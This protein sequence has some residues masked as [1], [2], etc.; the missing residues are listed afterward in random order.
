M[1]VHFAAFPAKFENPAKNTGEL[2]PFT[3][4]KATTFSTLSI[5]ESTVGVN[6]GIIGLVFISFPAAV[7]NA[8]TRAV[9]RLLLSCS[10]KDAVS[11]PQLA[12]TILMPL[13]SS[14]AS[15][16]KISDNSEQAV[17]E[18]ALLSSPKMSLLANTAK[19]AS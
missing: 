6:A 16:L 15:V 8:E 13:Y 11:N 7:T 9:S 10:D 2:F 19:D 14:P 1:I 17:Q 4:L 3:G 5:E 18:L 12:L